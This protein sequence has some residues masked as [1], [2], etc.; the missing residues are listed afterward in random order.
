M[1]T[2]ADELDRLAYAALDAFNRAIEAE[3]LEP[4]NIRTR[5]A[6]L[7][8]RTR[9]YRLGKAT[10]AALAHRKRE[11]LKRDVHKLRKAS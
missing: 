2:I 8:Y 3:M 7:E 11:E 9:L 6:W 5:E 1:T 4:G 10:N